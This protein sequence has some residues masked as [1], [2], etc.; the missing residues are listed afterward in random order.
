MVLFFYA[1][2]I[3]KRLSLL[4]QDLHF[5]VKVEILPD[6]VCG[7]HRQARPLRQRKA[8]PV[9]KG[10]AEGFCL[11]AQRPRTIGQILVERDNLQTVTRERRPYRATRLRP[12][13]QAW[14][15]SRSRLTAHMIASPRKAAARSAPGSLLRWARMTEASKTM[16]ATALRLGLPAPVC[17]QLVGK[18]HAFGKQTCQHG[19]GLAPADA[20]T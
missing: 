19:L 2:F 1:S 11:S 6:A 15:R 8:G 10:N 18:A 12:V 16:L 14:R 5:N 20:R 3:Q 17:D 13:P 4:P 9:A 7:Q